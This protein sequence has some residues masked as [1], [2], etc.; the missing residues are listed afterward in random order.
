M[1]RPKRKRPKKPEGSREKEEPHP[2]RTV[3]AAADRA[4]ARAE[5]AKADPRATT[6]LREEDR[7]EQLLQPLLRALRDPARARARNSL[8][9]ATENVSPDTTDAKTDR[10]D[11]AA[12]IT[13]TMRTLSKNR[14]VTRKNTRPRRSKSLQWKNSSLRA[15][16]Q[17]RCLSLWRVFP[18]RLRSASARSSWR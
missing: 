15:P 13:S 8:T 5:D 6:G 3:K 10:T 11:A 17:L 14:S 4:K 16:S 18:N 1:P 2:Q 9:T 7:A 12:A